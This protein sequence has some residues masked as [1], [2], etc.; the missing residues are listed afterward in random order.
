MRAHN[1][2]Q[3]GSVTFDQALAELDDHDRRHRRFLRSSFR[4]PSDPPE[5]YDLVIN[6][7]SAFSYGVITRPETAARRPGF[8]PTSSGS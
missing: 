4:R 2:M 8:T 5:R 7:S 3:D 1:I 6:N